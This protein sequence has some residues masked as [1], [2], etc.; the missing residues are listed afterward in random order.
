MCFSKLLKNI[1]LMK[2]IMVAEPLLLL[3]CLHHQTIDLKR[4]LNKRTGMDALCHRNDSNY[5]RYIK[6][7]L[8]GEIGTSEYQALQQCR[9]YFKILII[10]RQIVPPDARALQQCRVHFF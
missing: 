6:N 5:T 9:A 7:I 10:G 4:L 3:L 8:I 2:W 1:Q